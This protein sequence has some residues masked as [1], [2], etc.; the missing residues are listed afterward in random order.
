MN[1]YLRL[2]KK[3][4]S[5]ELSSELA[6]KINFIIKSLGLII[7]DLIGPIIM[8]LIYTI[9]SG[10]PGW[11]FEE[12][13][14][15]HGTFVFVIGLSHSLFFV[16]PLQVIENVRNGTFDK[17]L[18]KPFNP[19]LYLTFSS[20]DIEGFAEVFVG[21]AL[22]LW[23]IIKLNI[24]IF[25]FNMM[26]Y[27]LLIIMALIFLYSLMVLISSLAFLFVKS[28][29]LFDLLF[30][31]LDVGRY[32]M[33]IYGFE[34]KLIFTFILPI[35]VISFYPASV[36]LG[37]LSFLSLVEILTPVIVFLIFSIVMWNFAIKKYTSSGG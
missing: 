17:F 23:A 15:F 4:F 2:L 27:I 35:A 9:S 20:V 18:L 10:I 36:L 30:K 29:G 7:L 26:G 37:T 31:I 12:F 3:T 32:P 1:K 6:Y 8:L 13:I 33:N 16:F 11:R 5:M 28:F 21:L 22:V 19:L 25:S 34:M 24:I 14:L